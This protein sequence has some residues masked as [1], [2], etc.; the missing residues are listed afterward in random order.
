MDLSRDEFLT[1]IGNIRDDIKGV[2][3]RLDTMN[4]RTRTIEQSVAVLFDRADSVKIEALA[5]GRKSAGKWGALVAGGA[6]V[7]EVLH[8]YLGK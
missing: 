1:H 4:G 2:N 8:R 7:A 6:T 5:A 3:D